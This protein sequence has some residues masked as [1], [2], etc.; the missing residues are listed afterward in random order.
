MPMSPKFRQTVT[1]SLLTLLLVLP[2]LAQKA[3][4]EKEPPFREYKGVRIGMPADE[5][6]KKLGAPTD[7]GDT[8]DFYAFSESESAQIFYDAARKVSAVSVTFLG[9][10][11]KAP[12]VRAVL[13]ADAE[14]KPDGSLHK[15]VRYPKAGYWVSYSRSGG[16]SPMVTVAMQKL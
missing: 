16:D 4:E 3:D 13:G 8:Q 15:L 14:A 6:R 1:L 2:A 11:S 12:T 7:K 9:D 10:V 5:A